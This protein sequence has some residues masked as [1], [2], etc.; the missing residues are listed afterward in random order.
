MWISR[1]YRYIHDIYLTFN[2]NLRICHRL[3]IG[4]PLNNKKRSSL[5]P[6]TTK[7]KKII[8]KVVWN[9][10]NLFVTFSRFRWMMKFTKNNLDFSTARS[11]HYIITIKCVTK[12]PQ[13]ATV[14]RWAV[15]SFNFLVF[16]SVVLLLISTE[17]LNYLSSLSLEYIYSK[18]DNY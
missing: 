10:T 9:I 14:V 18:I 8:M 16:F 12:F 3:F 4:L 11:V 6:A 2:F 13:L 17:K 7:L 15:K 5:K 1:V